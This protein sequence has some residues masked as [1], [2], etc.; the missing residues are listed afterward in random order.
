MLAGP[1]ELHAKNTGGPLCCASGS[2]RQH[3]QNNT[4][5]FARSHIISDII[6]LTPAAAQVH[7]QINV[8]TV[9][10]LCLQKGTQNPARLITHRSIK[11]HLPRP[12]YSSMQAFIDRDSG[13]L[14]LIQ[15]CWLLVSLRLTQLLPSGVCLPFSTR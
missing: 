1:R 8:N 2:T 3:I 7:T 9:D 11:S 15:C 14:I 13:A 5:S 10:S 4:S 6:F 12:Y